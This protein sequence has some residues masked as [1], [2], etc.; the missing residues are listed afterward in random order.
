MM[1]TEIVP[2][3]WISF[4][5]LTRLMAREDLLSSVS[6]KAVAVRPHRKPNQSRLP[7]YTWFLECLFL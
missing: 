5:H 3:T 7:F 4:D 1:G 6:V 2:E